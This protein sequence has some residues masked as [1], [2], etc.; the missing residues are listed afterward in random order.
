MGFFIALVTFCTM[1][2]LYLIGLDTSIALI[3]GLVIG[4]GLSLLLIKYFQ[5]K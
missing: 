3:F 4:N 5:S 1:A 2:C